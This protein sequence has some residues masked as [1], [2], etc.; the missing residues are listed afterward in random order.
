M[1]RRRLLMTL[2][3]RWLEHPLA[4]GADLDDPATTA[5]R[6]RIIARKPF[7][8]AVYRDWHATLAP[9]VNR[10]VGPVVELGSGAAPLGDA[11]PQLFK[12]D[13]QL[14]PGIAA[15]LD[16][17][18]LPFRSSTLGA[19]VMTN[20]LHH[21][22]DVALFLSEAERTLRAGGTIAMIEP[23][24]TR[25]SRIVYTRLHHEPFDPSVVDWC[26][27]SG[28]PLTSANG[29]LPWIV[30]ARD[31]ARFSREFP[32]LEVTLIRPMMPVRY[33]LSGGVSARSLMPGWT[34]PGWRAFEAAATRVTSQ[35]AMFA[36]IV[37]QRR[38]TSPAGGR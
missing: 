38:D 36:L 21:V 7:L 6:H 27:P 22:P 9:H 28:A 35:F 12:T 37:V 2:V 23:W 17:C 10:D 5:L 14:V 19:I 31:A 34:T 15:V 18:H 16:A 4:R 30:F 1:G 24:V 33:V 32:G 29:A 13:I 8:Q 11:L 20:V 25:W 3:Q 26:L